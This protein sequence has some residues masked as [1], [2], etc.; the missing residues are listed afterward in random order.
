MLGADFASSP[1]RVLIDF[2]DPLVVAQK[3]AITDIS[4]YVTISEIVVE[5]KEGTSGVGGYR[6]RGKKKYLQM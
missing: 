2:V 1:G 4:R 6:A 5:L 3:V